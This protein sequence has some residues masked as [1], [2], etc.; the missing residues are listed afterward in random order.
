MS[1]EFDIEIL[2]PSKKLFASHGQEVVLPAYDGEVGVLPGHA[3][4]VGKLG[5]GALKVVVKGD[6][7]WFAVSGGVWQVNNGKLAVF[8]VLGE[9]ARHVDADGAKEKIAQLE[10]AEAAAKSPEEQ[11]SLAAEIQRQKAL[12][13]VHRRT[14]VVN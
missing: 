8:A 6:D 2:T 10:K 5:T 13:E 12:L 7:F 11:K 4:F 3:D 14:S 9:D 1:T